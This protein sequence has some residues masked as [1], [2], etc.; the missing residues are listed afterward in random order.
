MV[1]WS[2]VSM[3][4]GWDCMNSEI[5]KKRATVIWQIKMYGN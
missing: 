3:I 4:K 5:E 2:Y 1:W